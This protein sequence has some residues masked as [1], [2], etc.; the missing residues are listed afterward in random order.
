MLSDTLQYLVK[1]DDVLTKT[2][3]YVAVIHTTCVIHITTQVQWEYWNME[4]VRMTEI[5]STVI[6]CKYEITYDDLLN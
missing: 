6:T 3:G 2:V 4:G 5:L 1:F